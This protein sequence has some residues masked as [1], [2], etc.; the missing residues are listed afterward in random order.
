LTQIHGR[1]QDPWTVASLADTAAMSRSAFSARFTAL[2]GEPPLRYLSR[3][4]LARAATLLGT[5]RAKIKQAAARV[6]YESEASFSKAFKRVY[7]LAPGVWRKGMFPKL[8]TIEHQYATP[9]QQERHLEAQPC[10]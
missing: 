9:R 3:F 1:P 5:G 8:E 6:G 2:V 7:G 10:K 4:R